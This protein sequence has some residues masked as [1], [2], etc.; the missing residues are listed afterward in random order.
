[1]SKIFMCDCGE[2]AEHE[3]NMING[4]IVFLYDECRFQFDRATRAG[5]D[6]L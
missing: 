1:M 4:E 6:E 3:R 5:I 2:I